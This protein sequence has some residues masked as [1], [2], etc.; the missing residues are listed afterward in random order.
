MMFAQLV[1]INNIVFNIVNDKAIVNS[2]CLKWT[3]N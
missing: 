3:E 2:I 1:D